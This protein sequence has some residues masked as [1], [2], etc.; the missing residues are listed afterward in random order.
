MRYLLNYYREGIIGKRGLVIGA[1]L[2]KVSKRKKRFFLNDFVLFMWIR[3]KNTEERTFGE[4]FL[5]HD[6]DDCCVLEKRSWICV[7]TGFDSV[8]RR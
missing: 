6:R 3:K 7:K 8:A 2:G 1:T 5:F 4:I